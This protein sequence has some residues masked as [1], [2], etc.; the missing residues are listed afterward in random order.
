MR[1]SPVVRA[2]VWFVLLIAPLALVSS[3]ALV[4][5]SAIESLPTPPLSHWGISIPIDTTGCGLPAPIPPGTSAV[6][7]LLS[8]GIT[9]LYRLHIPPG[10]LPNQNTPLVLSFHGHGSSAKNQ[11][12]L[13]GFSALADRDGFLV[14]YPQ[15]TVGPDGRTGW[16]T[17][18]AN[19][20][21]VNDVRF[22]SDLLTRLQ[23]TL[24]V[25]PSRIYATGFSNGGAMTAMLACTMAGRIAAFAPVSGSYFPLVGGCHPSRPVSLLE[26]H[27]TAD[28]VVPYDGSFLLNL[29]SVPFWLAGWAEQDGCAPRPEVFYHQGDVTGEEWLRCRDDA[30]LVHYRIDGGRHAWPAALFS[31]VSALQFNATD[32]IWSFFS[33]HTLSL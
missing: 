20:P 3:S 29:P 21:T 2:I 15:G 6:E 10:Y 19:D 7:T 8:G 13:T 5:A 28:R 26:F 22:V 1:Q 30:S 25:D 14:V 4:Q 12:R 23:E 11:E 32:L 31:P 24:C 9:R 17:G 27:G 33:T 16:G 18:P